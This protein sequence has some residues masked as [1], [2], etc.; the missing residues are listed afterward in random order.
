VFQKPFTGGHGGLSDLKRTSKFIK[1]LCHETGQIHSPC[2]LDCYSLYLEKIKD[3]A[4]SIEAFYFRP[5][6]DGAFKYEKIPIGIN[7]LSKILP[8]KLCK[9]AGITRKTAHCMRITCASRLF[10]NNINE[11]QTRE[12]TGHRSDSLFRY[13]RPSAEQVKQVS[14]ALAPPNATLSTTLEKSKAEISSLHEETSFNA[15][16]IP[17]EILADV[18]IPEIST[19]ALQYNLFDSEISDELLAT[20]YVP[21]CDSASSNVVNPVFNNCTVNFWLK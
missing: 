6:R 20:L 8:E 18:K 21:E 10:Q 13:Q 3:Y 15:P 9:A 11:K 1:H 2:L 14:N 12:R 4:K 5:A 16:E 7:T 19:D 17:D